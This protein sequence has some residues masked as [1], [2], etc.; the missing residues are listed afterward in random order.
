MPNLRSKI[1]TVALVGVC[2]WL[3]LLV[4]SAQVHYINARRQL[5]AMDDRIIG[6]QK[7][8]DRLSHELELMRQPDWLALLARARLNYKRPD[9][10]VVFV[11]K[12]DKSSIIAQ[13]TTKPSERSNF[14]KWRDWLTG[15]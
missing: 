15:N 2:V 11:Y 3:L 6:A 1:L 9:E 4:V 12:N 10:N 13:P 5:S 8:N 7:E 14:Q